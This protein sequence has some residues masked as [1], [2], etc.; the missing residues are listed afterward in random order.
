MVAIGQEPQAQVLGG[1]RLKHVQRLVVQVA[2]LQLACRGF[3]EREEGLPERGTGLVTGRAHGLQDA[4]GR[5]VTVAEGGHDGLA[6]LFEQLLDG[7]RSALTGA[8]AGC[9]AGRRGAVRAGVGPCMGRGLIVAEMEGERQ[10]IDEEAHHL[11]Q[12][13]QLTAAHGGA[14]AQRGLPRQAVQ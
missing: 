13:G 2:P 3:L 4:V 7:V 5:H 10:G 1:A 11:L 12:L 8:G 9:H 6:D 14:D